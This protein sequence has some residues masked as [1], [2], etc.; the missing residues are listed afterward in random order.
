MSDKTK[1]VALILAIVLPNLGVFGAHRFY[2]GHIGIG[3]G[4]FLT[5]GGCGIWQLIDIIQ[6]FTGKMTDSEGRELS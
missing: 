3:I 2:L 4:Q 1:T 5:L 6:I